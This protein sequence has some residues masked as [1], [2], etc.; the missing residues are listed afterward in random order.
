MLQLLCRES[1]RLQLQWQVRETY[2]CWTAPPIMWIWAMVS[3]LDSTPGAMLRFPQA[4]PWP[5]HQIWVPNDH[6]KTWKNYPWAVLFNKCVGPRFDHPTL[7]TLSPP[8]PTSCLG[9]C[10]TI[11]PWSLFARGIPKRL[12][13]L[14][15][16]CAWS[17]ESVALPSAAWLTTSWRTKS[18]PENLIESVFSFAHWIND[19]MGMPSR[20]TWGTVGPLSNPV[21]VNQDGTQAPLSYR[22]KVVPNPQI[23]AFKPKK[24]DDTASMENLKSS[25]LGA[26][27]H[28]KYSQLPVNE[29][30]RV[31]WEARACVKITIY[32][33]LCLHFIIICCYVLLNLFI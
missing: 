8:S 32:I 17:P 5:I 20:K 2:G 24:L 9:V 1:H 13:A 14:R 29:S 12:S 26:V 6:N 15:R 11:G 18:R 23:N 27:F 22:Y 21:Q 16:S 33:Y 25:V 4:G 30:C 19:I 10:E 3:S 31:T 28:K 7:Q